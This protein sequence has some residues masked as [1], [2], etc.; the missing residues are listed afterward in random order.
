MIT[1]NQTK[2]QGITLVVSVIVL[3]I[4]LVLTVNTIKNTQTNA[5]I[6]TNFQSNLQGQAA[7]QAA[8][9]EGQ[10]YLISQQPSST[11]FTTDCRSGLCVQQKVEKVWNSNALWQNAKPLQS[12]L[13]TKGKIIGTPSY[14]IEYVGD[15]YYQD[16]L[17][18]GSEYGSNK[19]V[20]KKP[21]Y[22]ITGKA[23]GQK[24]QKQTVIQSTVY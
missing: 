1:N 2:Q 20:S 4:V 14:L 8:V 12:T 7:A 24:G 16:S 19:D 5:R 15:K 3:T 23:Q 6:A 18:V 17:S 21:I 22:R 9:L 11:Q 13:K 10:Q